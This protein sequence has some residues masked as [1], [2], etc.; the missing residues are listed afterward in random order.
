MQTSLLLQVGHDL[1]HHFTRDAHLLL[2]TVHALDVDK[3]RRDTALETV[4][5][6]FAYEIAEHLPLREI[7]W[8]PLRRVRPREEFGEGGKLVQDS[9][10]I[11]LIKL[12]AWRSA[13]CGRGSAPH[14]LMSE[15]FIRRKPS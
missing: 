2:I 12:R 15:P 13:I 3:E 14:V 8:Y 5:K 1:L 10:D 6:V 11:S 9:R 4:D 7:E